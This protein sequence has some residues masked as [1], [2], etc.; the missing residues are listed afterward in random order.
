MAKMASFVPIRGT[1]LAEARLPSRPMVRAASFLLLLSALGLHAQQPG[2]RTWEPRLLGSLTIPF[3]VPRVVEHTTDRATSLPWAGVTLGVGGS[4][5]YKDRWGIA[6]QGTYAMQGYLLWVDSVCYDLYHLLPRAEVRLWAQ[7]EVHWLPSDTR[8]R[9][10][11]GAGLGFQTSSELRSTEDPFTIVTR[12]PTQTRPYLAPELGLMH[13]DG[14]RRMELGLRYL[15]HLDRSPA[16]TSTASG[17]DGT[18]TYSATDDHLAL[19]VRMHFGFPRRELPTLPTPAPALSGR[20]A[21]TLTTLAT[22]RSRITLQLWDNAEYDGDTI[23]VLLND[24]PVLVGHEL[25]HR[26]HRLKLDLWPG[27]NTVRVVAHNEGRVPP[28]TA[29]CRVN[30]GKGRKELLI[31]TSEVADQ[32]MVVVRE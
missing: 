2:P 16:W 21:D 12:E 10:G 17:P 31:R 26:K 9:I 15:V 8:L 24:R 32:V 29:S 30:L 20:S 11:M 13:F 5:T 3:Q 7:P 1:V 6:V 28:N 18:A 4:L 22:S 25:T 27:N 19:V 23:T 14:P